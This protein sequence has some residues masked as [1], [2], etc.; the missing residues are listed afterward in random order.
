MD[1]VATHASHVYSWLEHWWK[2]NSRHRSELYE[3]W[4]EIDCFRWRKTMVS[5]LARSSTH[6]WLF[7]SGLD[8]W[9]CF[10]FQSV[11]HYPMKGLFLISSFL[12]TERN[13]V[14]EFFT[15]SSL[16]QKPVVRP[17]EEFEKCLFKQRVH[18]SDGNWPGISLCQ[19]TWK[20]AQ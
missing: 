6:S 13:Q 10:C 15:Q 5:F 14:D 11:N 19:P 20:I 16:T 9:R 1:R 17:R 18:S 2:S 4:K 7:T 12:A 8:V 3:R